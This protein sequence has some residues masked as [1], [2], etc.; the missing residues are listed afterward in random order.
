VQK[1]LSPEADPPKKEKKSK[2]R[3]SELAEP[4]AAPVD[5]DVVMGDA[6]AE[7]PKV[8]KKSKKR[9]SEVIEEQEGQD[10]EVS[11]KHKAVFSKFEKASKLAEA[12]KDQVEADE[13]DQQPEEELHGEH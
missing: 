9:K 3:K 5:E 1:A 2:K 13:D 6:P 4:V 11:K 8:S 10:E 7:A 12:R